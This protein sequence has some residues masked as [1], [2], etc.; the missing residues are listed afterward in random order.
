MVINIELSK[1]KILLVQMLG[2]CPH[3]SYNFTIL[4]YQW[5]LAWSSE[6]GEAAT[7]TTLQ[8]HDPYKWLED[9]IIIMNVDN[10]EKQSL[11]DNNIHI[12]KK[13]DDV[14]NIDHL[15]HFQ[16][17]LQKKQLV[18]P[19]V[20][21]SLSLQVLLGT[22]PHSSSRTNSRRSWVKISQNCMI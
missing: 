16:E 7:T 22:K 19:D 17:N 6:D 21:I 5:T 12:C 8:Q 11:S 20:G 1:N 10:F 15:T 18:H 9:S 13:G 2:K 14:A 4:T 3:F